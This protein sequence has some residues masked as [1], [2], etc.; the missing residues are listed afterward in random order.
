MFKQLILLPFFIF[1]L[2]AEERPK[3][4]HALSV[5]VSYTD[6]EGKEIKTVI[7]RDI[8]ARCR[9]LPFNGETYWSG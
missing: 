9:E 7:A 5:H 3:M 8:D 6:A 4:I 1:V 2:F